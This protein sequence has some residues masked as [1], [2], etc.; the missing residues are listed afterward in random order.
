MVV[1]NNLQRMKSP[2]EQF[3]E[4]MFMLDLVPPEQGK[5][6][7]LETKND[8]ANEIV[9]T[10]KKGSRFEKVAELM[11]HSISGGT[12]RR[13]HNVKAF[14]EKA[15]KEGDTKFLS[16]GIIERIKTGEI[17]P[18]NAENIIKHY[19][20]YKNERLEAKE[21][22][23]N[24]LNHLDSSYKLFNKSSEKMEEVESD[25]IQ[26]VFS[27]P[28]YFQ[29]RDYGNTTDEKIEIGHEKTPEEFVES[30]M[31]HF[32]EVHRVLKN[33][34]SFFMNFGEYGFKQYSPLVSNMLILRLHQEGLFKCISEIILH[35]TNM[36]PISCNKR[37]M[38]SYEKIYH[39]VKDHKNYT[40]NPLKIWREEDEMKIVHS[41]NNRGVNGT[42]K[43][44]PT[45]QKPYKTFRD[46]I[47]LQIYEDVI[48]SSGANT[49][50]Y[51]KIDPD[52]D[53]SAPY[54]SKICMIGLLCCSSPQDTVLDMFSG[55]AS[56][57][58]A[59][60]MLGRNYIGYELNP[61]YHSFAMKRLPFMTEGYNREEV[62][63]FELL[64]CD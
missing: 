43:S 58:E 32:R 11:D 49:A 47:D 44:N 10:K 33:T 20:K 55:T 54:D 57:G 18:S 22:E 59:A 28:P 48:K 12:I 35:K 62:E 42:V 7:D 27:S 5:R 60:L 4:A 63:N 45:L 61:S 1:M 9:V 13:M 36:K 8:P 25:S 39:L 37:L 30:L 50:M 16:L 34:G 51:K 14:H 21:K 24:N 56:T 17:T 2:R 31:P 26:V 19:N 40:Y 52:F 64:K 53:H 38:R 3:L 23:I 29:A 15:E 6:N 46:F 41:F